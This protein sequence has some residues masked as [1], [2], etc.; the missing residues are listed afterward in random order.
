ML[1]RDCFAVALGGAIGSV[2]RYGVS[3]YVKSSSSFPVHTFLVNTAGSFLIGLIAGWAASDERFQQHW[4]L[5]LATGICGGFTT[6]S[7][8]SLEGIQM[9]QQQ[10]IGLYVLYTCGS[11]FLGLL[12]AW[13][14]YRLIK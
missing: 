5:F 4:Q 8:F 12:A 6:F 3:L 11:V 9:L 7:T 2:L 14:G 13:I 1:F 10:K